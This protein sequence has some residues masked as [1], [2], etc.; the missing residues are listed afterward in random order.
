MERQS[1]YRGLL[2]ADT[3]GIRKQ[4]ASEVQSSLEGLIIPGRGV[5]QTLRRLFAWWHGL[6]G[7]SGVDNYVD[8]LLCSSFCYNA[9]DMGT[10]M[11]T[12]VIL[13]TRG[14]LGL[15]PHPVATGD[16]LI[17]VADSHPLIVRGAR[18]TY[19]LQTTACLPVLELGGLAGLFASNAIAV[20]RIT[21]V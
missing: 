5:V 7:M 19:A 21:L 20:E 18:D 12:T 11:G 2:G 15:C 8:T 1:T 4:Y 10:I 3:Q 17:L 14:Y 16:T 13:T 9:R 6:T